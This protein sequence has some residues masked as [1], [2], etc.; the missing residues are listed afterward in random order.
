MLLQSNFLF[1]VLNRKTIFSKKFSYF[2]RVL[3]AFAKS[4]VLM[5]AKLPEVK[6]NLLED[7]QWDCIVSKNTCFQQIFMKEKI[8]KTKEILRW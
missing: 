6:N 8:K 2:L 5:T 1:P 4:F 7:P 3:F